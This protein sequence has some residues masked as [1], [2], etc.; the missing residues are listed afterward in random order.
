MKTLCH[1]HV[2]SH[3]VGL[4]YRTIRMLEHGVKPVYVFDGKPPTLKRGELAKR[5]ERREEAQA[6][7]E[8]AREDGNAEEEQKMV[9]RL[10]KVTATHNAEAKQLLRLMGVP[11]MEAPGE[12]EAQCAVLTNAGRVFATAT[13][14]MDALCFGARILVRHLCASEARK[15]PIQVS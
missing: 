2:F 4:F 13:D 6:N 5:T 14:D 9:K 8:R 11:V 10:V 7:L 1:C 15:L 3:L 12:A